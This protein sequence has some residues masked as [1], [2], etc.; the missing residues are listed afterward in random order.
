MVL[1]MPKTKPPTDP[2]AVNLDVKVIIS[3]LSGLDEYDLD[4][5]QRFMI[6][7]RNHSGCTTPLES[8]I[9]NL[10]RFYSPGCN[11]RPDEIDQEVKQF[12]GEFADAIA[13]AQ[14]M[15]RD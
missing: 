12:K 15:L 11:M 3:L 6:I 14:R 7:L 9:Y 4:M 10:V 1:V 13:D 5:V 8:L 2:P